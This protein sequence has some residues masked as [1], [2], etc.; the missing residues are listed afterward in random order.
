MRS[1]FG[2]WVLILV[3]SLSLCIVTG[4][5]TYLLTD[6]SLLAKVVGTT[7]GVFGI[8]AAYEVWERFD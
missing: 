1:T 7:F 8:F 2:L 5:P 6:S 3:F 4:L